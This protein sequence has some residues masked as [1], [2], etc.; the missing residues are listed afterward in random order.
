MQYR[1]LNANREVS[2]TNDFGS[3][4]DRLGRLVAASQCMASK[5]KYGNWSFLCCGGSGTFMS[6]EAAVLSAL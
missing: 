4:S 1:P 6:Q 2:N 3:V 5:D